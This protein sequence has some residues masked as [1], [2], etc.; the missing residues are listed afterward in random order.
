M[1]DK[2]K[3]HEQVVSAKQ[4]IFNAEK[5][6]DIVN[7]VFVLHND[8]I[9]YLGRTQGVP[10]VYAFEKSKQYHATHFYYEQVSA[11]DVDNYLAE[12]ILKFQPM[13][14]NRVPK[15]TKFISSHLAKEKYFISKAEFKKIY[16]EFGGYKFNTLLFIEK[17][18]FDDVFAISQPYHENM[19]KLGTYIN[20]QKDYLLYPLDLREQ[21]H[22]RYI[23]EDGAIVDEFINYPENPEQKYKNLQ[24]LQELKYEVVQHLDSIHFKAINQEGVA[25]VLSA[26]DM[27][28]YDCSHGNWGKF[29]NDWNIEAIKESYF[30]SLAINLP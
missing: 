13:Y 21:D 12:L 17:K 10:A 20:L 1:L 14:N 2:I 19:P 27:C 25:V 29:L 9:V 3:K 5:N 4:K 11:S 22:N 28:N 30:N 23:N 6:D 18:I 26:G 24:K 7:I 16:K 8:D 15:N